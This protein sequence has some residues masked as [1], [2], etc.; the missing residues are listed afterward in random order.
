MT[1]FV[2][3]FGLTLVLFLLPLYIHT[4]TAKINSHQHFQDQGQLH[5]SKQQPIR[6]NH[7]QPTH[8]GEQQLT[9]MRGNFTYFQSVLILFHNLIPALF[10]R[11]FF[12]VSAFYKVDNSQLYSRIQAIFA[13][14]TLFIAVC[15]YYHTIPGFYYNHYPNLHEI[16]IFSFRV[17]KIPILSV[18]TLYLIPVI[19]I[20]ELFQPNF[21]FYTNILSL[22]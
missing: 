14:T 20:L 5:Q 21:H 13:L 12:F 6:I 4:T 18:I 15:T 22:N 16:D 17:N 19:I 10:S 11:T 2:D 8:Q 3:F 1:L 9:K 7:Q